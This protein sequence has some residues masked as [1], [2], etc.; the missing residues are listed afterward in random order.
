V[1][2]TKLRRKIP[3]VVEA[4]TGHFDDHHA[5]IVGRL[6]GRL[7]ATEQAVADLDAYLEVAMTPWAHEIDLLTTIPGAGRVVAWTFIA[8]T[9]GDMSRFPG[10]GHLASWAGLAPAMHESAGRRQPVG[11]RP[12]NRFLTAM[13]VEAALS[14]SRTKDTYLAGQFAHLTSRRGHDRA[15]VAVAH[16]ILVSACWTLVRDQPDDDLGPG[17]LTNHAAEQARTRRLVNQLEAL[18]HTVLSTPPP[19]TNPKPIRA[20]PGAVAH[21][22]PDIHGSVL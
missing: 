17:W 6:L 20:P 22:L 21:P 4:L 13:L 7:A 9:G 5:L 11:T 3:D 1:A 12:G 2:R 8:E 14:A 10:P 18:G 15:A 16:P 19:E